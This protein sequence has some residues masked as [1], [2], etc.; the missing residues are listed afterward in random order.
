MSQRCP[1]RRQKSIDSYCPEILLTKN[2]LYGILQLQGLHRTGNR[3]VCAYAN[4][5][6]RPEVATMNV[7]RALKRAEEIP[8]ISIP[9]PDF[10]VETVADEIRKQK[11]LLFDNGT[12]VLKFAKY[13]SRLS[14][15]ECEAFT[16][17]L[18]P[19]DLQIAVSNSQIKEVIRRLRFMPQLQI[20]L[21]AEFW[22]SQ[23]FVNLKNGVYDIKRQELVY[24]RDEFVFDYCLSFDYRARS[25]LE[26]APVFKRFVDSSLGLE[27]LECLLR[28]I[29]YVLS[30]LTK[31]RKA[32]VFFGRGRTGKSTLLN[33]LEAVIGDGFVSHQPFFTVSHER[34]KAHYPGMR[35]NIC[36]ETSTK[37]N[38]CEEGFKSLVSC[39]YNTG[40]EKYQRQCD[41]IATLSFVFAGNTDLEF[42]VLDDAILDRL[43]YVMFTREIHDEE[44]DLDLEEKLLAEKDVIFSIALDSLKGLIEDRYDFKMGSAA[45]K[46]L[47]HRRFMI[48]SPESFLEEKC[49]LSASGKV[50]KV[51][52]YAAYV[53]FCEANALKPEGRNRFYDRVRSYHAAITDGRVL[54][55]K[56]NSVQGFHGI[57]LISAEQPADESNE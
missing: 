18:L 40:A 17:A 11:L 29:G 31:G 1:I 54:D 20:D 38:R 21:E 48:H 41:F 7:Q 56:G 34:S 46:H 2:A 26:D 49:R 42:G 45:K 33:V 51:T 28:I 4:P 57:S 19:P 39:E 24:N 27:Q 47:Q 22:K 14:P 9:D 13:Y 55:S 43:V 25:K 10:A 52:L 12:A 30:S 50:S 44:I 35:A 23:M 15:D 6:T 8:K 53:T 16:V 37:V 5:Q 3:S 36:R 32:F